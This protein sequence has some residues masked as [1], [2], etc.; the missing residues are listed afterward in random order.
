[1]SPKP[2]EEP[3]DHDLFRTDPVNLVDQRDDL[4]RLVELIDWAIPR[5]A[6]S[7]LLDRARELLVDTARKSA[8]ALHKT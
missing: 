5:S 3:T 4:V 7:E 1:M 2:L 8:T 6:D